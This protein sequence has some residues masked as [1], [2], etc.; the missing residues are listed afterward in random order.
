VAV[1]LDP[2]AQAVPHA[3]QL[4]TDVASAASQ[5]LAAAPSQLPKPREHVSPQAPA[6][7]VASELDPLAQALPQRPQLP[8]AVVR[9]VSQPLAATPSQSPKPTLHARRHAPAAQSGEA[10]AP[11]G[12]TV[13]QAPQLVT[14]VAV[15]T[16]VV[17]QRVVPAAQ[18]SMQAPA[19]QRWPVGHARPHAPQLLESV[20]V[21]TSQPLAA[22]PSQLVK[23][24]LHVNPQ[25]EAAQVEVALA[26]AGHTV[27]QAPQLVAA[28]ARL[29]SQPL[30]MPMSQSAK[31]AAQVSPQAPPAQVGALLGRAAQRFPHAP[32]L[33]MSARGS[34]QRPP[35]EM[36]VPG[37]AHT[38]EV[39]L[40]PPAQRLPHAPQWALSLSGLTQRPAHSTCPEGHVHTR[41][42]QV[43]PPM[44]AVPQRPQ[45]ALSL[46][47]S[48]QLE[49]Q[50]D[51]PMGQVHTPAAQVWSARQVVP[52]EPQLARSLCGSTQ[53]IVAPV[54]QMR[55]GEGQPIWQVPPAQSCPAGQALPQALQLRESV[56]RSTQAAP[57]TVPVPGHVHR[58]LSQV[59]PLG[60][61]LPH[62]PQLV[63]LLCVSTQRP[64]Q[65]FWPPAHWHD[66]PTQVC[67]APHTV[68]QVP[69]LALSLCVSRH[70]CAAPA[71]Q[72]TRG[73]AQ[74]I[75]QA[76]VVQL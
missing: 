60:H 67:A 46:R 37:Q 8:V 16:Q 13:P 43:V 36:P 35:H 9:L 65:L 52:Q 19:E 54:P 33:L 27:P 40:V 25:A 63:L 51:W 68:P 53:T 22:M 4:E 17:P 49:P 2:L 47:R 57:Q 66:P 15:A 44:Q 61:A 38:P 11:V 1:E 73:A 75:A 23:P 42:M 58:P 59:W 20:R 30:A 69:Q 74:G 29:V 31:P 34:M 5:P 24:A 62:M 26:R 6:L 48:T 64:P 72:I 39:Q 14:L 28:V 32:Q 71:P 10:L 7:H 56:P 70:V 21:L 12:H 55:R 41:S 50:A 45:L 18:V 3:P 76:P